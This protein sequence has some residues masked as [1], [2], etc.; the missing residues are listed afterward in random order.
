M[1]SR[2][3]LLNNLQR[4]MQPLAHWYD[5]IDSHVMLELQ[6]KVVYKVLHNRYCPIKWEPIHEQLTMLRKLLS[7]I[8]EHYT[9][10]NG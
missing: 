5:I 10:D 8:S 1:A 7:H 2:F 6:S 3:E 9:E 4:A